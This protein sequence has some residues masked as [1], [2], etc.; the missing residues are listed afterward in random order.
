[1]YRR[2]DTVISWDNTGGLLSHITPFTENVHLWADLMNIDPV[3][4]PEWVNPSVVKS[5]IGTDKRLVGIGL[6][7]GGHEWVRSLK[8][9][10]NFEIANFFGISVQ[11]LTRESLN[12]ENIA[13]YRE[14]SG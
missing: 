8:F 2:R 3:F 11:K 1:M 13:D 5:E 10:S 4:H 7:D 6:M 12:A 9:D 14:P